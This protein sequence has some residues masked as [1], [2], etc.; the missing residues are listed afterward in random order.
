MF[1]HMKLCQKI[2]VVAL[3]LMMLCSAATAELLAGTSSLTIQK[4]EQVGIEIS[5]EVLEFLAENLRSNIR[6]IEGAIKKLSALSFLSGKNVS[7]DLAKSCL[8]ELLGGA[9]PVNV[10]VEKIF[11]AVPPLFRISCTQIFI[12]QLIYINY[13]LI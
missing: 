10:T 13:I 12:K 3:A 4:A 7:M 9:E 8:S 2:L 6:Q 5:E 1:F 11:S